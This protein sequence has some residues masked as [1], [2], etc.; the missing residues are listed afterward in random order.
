MEINRHIEI[1]CTLLRMIKYICIHHSPLVGK[2]S[3]EGIKGKRPKNPFNYINCP[4]CYSG[5]L[6]SDSPTA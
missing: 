2:A 4:R 1:Y 3:K 5:S 6:E